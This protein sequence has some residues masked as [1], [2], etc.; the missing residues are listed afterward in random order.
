[1]FPARPIVSIDDRPGPIILIDGATAEI[2]IPS[3]PGIRVIGIL[4]QAECLSAYAID[5]FKDIADEA[6]LIIDRTKSLA[7]RT[8]ALETQ[9]ASSVASFNSYTSQNW[10]NNANI[11]DTSRFDKSSNSD[12]NI[13]NTFLV[14]EMVA[15]AQPAPDINVFKDAIPSEETTVLNQGTALERTIPITQLNFNDYF[16]KPSWF[17]EQYS[18]ELLEEINKMNEE[19]KRKKEQEKRDKAAQAE[20]NQKKKTDKGAKNVREVVQVTDKIPEPPK[21]LCIPPPKGQARHT[22]VPYS[23][24]K[25]GN[26]TIVTRPAFTPSILSSPAPASSSDGSVPPPPPPPPPGGLAGKAGPPPPPP[27]PGADGG[28][29]GQTHLDLIKSGQFK[30]KKVDTTSTPAPAAPMSHLDLIKSGQFHLKKVSDFRPPPPKPKE[31]ERDPNTLTVQE[32]LEKAAS[33]RS[34]VACSD[35]EDEESEKSSTTSW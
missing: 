27:P 22:D 26:V 25:E 28:S 3:I 15:K 30:L 17:R 11:K 8:K 9:F 24:Q 21:C 13:I 35:S 10:P 6:Q 34:A 33:I 29:G 7:D 18:K 5:I 16:T 14:N 12:F 2:A 1:M 31:E 32:I 19:R 4:R 20:K 23:L